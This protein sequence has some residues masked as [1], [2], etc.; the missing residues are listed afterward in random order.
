[1]TFNPD[2]ADLDHDG[3][4]DA[5]DNCRVTANHDQADLDHDGVGDACDNCRGTSNP[6]QADLDH[7]GVGDACD[8]CRRTANTN[9]ADMDGDGVGDACDNCRAKPNSDQRDTDGDGVG[10]ACDN[11]P[12][13]ANSDQRDT[14]GDGVGDVCTPF[15]F[16]AG[17]EFVVGDQVNMASGVTVYFWGSLWSQ[18]NPMSGG[19]APNSFKGFE[20]GN[21]LP[22]C[23]GTW[24][25]QPGNS[26]NPPA[27]IP[28]YMGV[29]VSSSIHQDGSVI[30]GDIKKIII[31]KTNP[32]Y[33][34]SPGHPGTGQVVA[35][36]CSS[37]PLASFWHPLTNPTATPTLAWLT[38]GGVE[39]WSSG[40][41]KR[42]FTLSL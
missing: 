34:P 40:S 4:G 39:S 11:C 37:G 9:Q 41:R 42:V 20:N 8:N 10:D 19:S 7:D 29:I 26:S 22:T 28:P 33:G 38:D 3:V 13:T 6:D 16:P 18:N 31:V 15:E 23:G 24:T 21:D 12:S 25:S 2:Q 36:F 17:A 35:I 27:T 5:C 1:M 30:S 32:G 14:N